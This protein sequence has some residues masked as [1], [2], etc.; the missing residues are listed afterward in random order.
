MQRVPPLH[1]E[2]NDGH[3]DGAHDGDQSTCSVTA[4]RVVNRRGQGDVA[5][6]EEEKNQLRGQAGIPDPPSAPHGLAPQRASPKG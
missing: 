1:R 3:I 5:K 2:I 6:V 4:T